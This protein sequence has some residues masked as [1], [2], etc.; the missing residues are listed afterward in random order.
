MAFKLVVCG[1]RDFANFE[2]MQTKLDHLLSNKRNTVIV[3]G[4]ARGADSLG[5]KYARLRNLKIESYPADWEFYGKSAG[6]LRNEQM[7][8]IADG[9]CAFWDGKSRGTAHMIE[10]ARKKVIPLRIIFY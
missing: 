1:G 8:E 6:Y 2:L 5:C 9:V 10:L 4:V 3:S 7:A